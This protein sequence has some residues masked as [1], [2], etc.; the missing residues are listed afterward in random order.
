MPMDMW[1]TQQGKAQ[2]RLHVD[3]L[4]NWMLDNLADKANF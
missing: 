1:I 2:K 3:N 4:A